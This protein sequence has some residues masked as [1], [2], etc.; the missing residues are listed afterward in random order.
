MGYVGLINVLHSHFTHLRHIIGVCTVLTA[1]NNVTFSSKAFPV[2]LKRICVNLTSDGITVSNND[3]MI[4]V[5]LE[6]CQYFFPFCYEEQREAPTHRGMDVSPSSRLT[7]TESSSVL[8]N[9]L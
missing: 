1:V 6:A 5:T 9:K 3:I 4:F 8:V 7:L 2:K